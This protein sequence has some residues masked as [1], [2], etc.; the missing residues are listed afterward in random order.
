MLTYESLLSKKAY[1]PEKKMVK[2]GKIIDFS[3][4]NGLDNLLS[5]WFFIAEVFLALTL[6]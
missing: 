2:T 1:H 5:G 6:F 4:A 3:K